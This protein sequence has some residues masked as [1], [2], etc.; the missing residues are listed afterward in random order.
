M[1]QDVRG[2]LRECE[3]V[4]NFRV[5]SGTGALGSGSG[6]F[7]GGFVD[8]HNGKVIFYGVNAMALFALQALGIQAVFERLLVGGADENVEQRFRKHES[9]LRE[10]A[11]RVRLR[12]ERAFL[13]RA[14]KSF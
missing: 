7:D 2:A 8:E 1:G 4:V 9:I 12:R 10:I 5:R 14:R 6:S 11:G 13:S 3:A